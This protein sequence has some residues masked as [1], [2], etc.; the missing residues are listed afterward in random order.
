MKYILRGHW[1]Q[2]TDVIIIKFLVTEVEK[3]YKT[4]CTKTH[5]LKLKTISPI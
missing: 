1:T 5:Q 3:K 4:N 2:M